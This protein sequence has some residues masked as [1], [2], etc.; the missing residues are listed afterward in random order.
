[1]HAC[2]SHIRVDPS[3]SLPLHQLAK[4]LTYTDC[5]F[6]ARSAVRDHLLQILMSRLKLLSAK[7]GNGCSIVASIL[8]AYDMDMICLFDAQQ[9]WDASQSG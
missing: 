2:H 7:C 1:V 3:V 6:V 9:L 5:R 4:Q 8:C